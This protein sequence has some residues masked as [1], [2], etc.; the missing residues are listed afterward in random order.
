MTLHHQLSEEQREILRNNIA[1]IKEWSIRASNTWLHKSVLLEV[2]MKR[3]QNGSQQLEILDGYDHA[4]ALANKSGFVHDAAFINERCGIW[5]HGISRKRAIPYLQNAFRCYMTWGATHKANEIKKNFGDEMGTKGSSN[6]SGMSASVQEVFAEEHRPPIYSID[7][8]SQLRDIVPQSPKQSPRC[9]R[10]TEPRD[11]EFDA[12]AFMQSGASLS[13]G[14]GGMRDLFS[15]SGAHDDDVASQSSSTRN[16]DSSLG[17]ELDL[18]TVLKASLV[19]SEGIHLEEVIVSLMTC[20]LQTAGADYGVLI[21]MEE[22]NL[23]VETVGLLDQVTILEHEP[24]HTRPDL[25]PVSVVNLVAS[26]GEQI[27]RNGDDPKFELTY[28]RDVYFRGKNP[29]SLLCMPVRNQL[30]TMGILYLEN[31]LINHVF[32]RQRQELLNLL[33]TQAAVTIDKARLYRQ[34]ELA[35]KEAEEASKEK[36]T[37]LANMSHEIRTPFNALL[38]CSIFLMDTA[39]T[40]QQ[41]EYVETI[42]SSSM[43]TLSI[44]DGILDF[45]KASAL[46]LQKTPFSLRDCVE[47]A[48]LLVA[49]PAATKDL[50]LAYRN[51]CSNIEFIV[52]DITRFRQCV[53]NLIG[54]AVKFTEV[55]YIVVT[56]QAE[57]LPNDSKWRIQV[58][59]KDTGIGIPRGAFSRLFRAFSQVDTSTSRTYGGT[60]LGLA[61]SKKLAQMMGGDIWFESEEGKGATFHFTIVADVVQKIWKPD[62][63]LEGKKAIVADSHRI[64]SHILAN[65]LE[66]EGLKVTRT[67]DYKSTLDALKN[68]GKG[69][70]DVALVDLSVDNSYNIFDRFAEFDPAC[71][72]ILMSRFGANIPPSILNHKCTLSFVRPA[73]R[74]RYVSAVHDAL[75]PALRKMEVNK[76]KPEQEMLKTLATRHPLKILL[77]EDN[78]VNTRVALQHLKRMGYSAMHAKDGIEVLELCEEA[79][80]SGGMFD[81]S[82]PIDVPNTRHR[83]PTWPTPGRSPP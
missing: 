81:V 28:G 27:L 72:V 43:L 42:R 73:P 80:K 10:I 39:L 21:L 37:F 35:K 2:E 36:S 62:P 54:N 17:S 44:I 15:A 32:T 64:S 8:E 20:V 70:Y 40:E 57:Q 52:G 38:S 71:K 66:V 58:S 6:I 46:D 55:G 68:A 31:K 48:L 79:E 47:G 74:N 11:Y 49:E 14:G 63:R 60:G 18:R 7:S 23:H 16:N 53:I 75:N 83:R 12:G 56:S 19:I 26:L 29:K 41:R 22:G 61:I 30:K 76:R 82:F 25:V 67:S 34:M 69:F 13:S 3:I 51:N 24:L 5:L 45:S 9:T 33:C 50:E 4:I 78:V 1:C 65:E 77:A 59:V